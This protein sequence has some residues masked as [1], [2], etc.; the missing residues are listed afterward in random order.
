MDLESSPTPEGNG[1]V[2]PW[3]NRLVAVVTPVAGLIAA[4]AA[5]VTA[6]RS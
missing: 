3:V 5:L 4:V 2:P 6:L 1:G